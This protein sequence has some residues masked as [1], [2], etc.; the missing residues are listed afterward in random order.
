[1]KKLSLAVLAL[2]LA[3]LAPDRV[4]AQVCATCAASWSTGQAPDMCTTVVVT[5]T[6]HDHG[7]CTL[8]P[9][10]KCL[11]RAVCLFSATVT[12][13]D[14][15]C[16]GAVY[17]SRYCTGAVNSQGQPIGSPICGGIGPFTSPVTL[18]DFPV[19]CGR[20]DWLV[21]ERWLNGV[22]SVIAQPTGSC[23]ACASQAQEGDG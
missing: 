11:P 23:S 12:I 9:E 8:N 7:D 21:F 1:M 14:L 4:A 16:G 15:G 19:A 18:S 17:W 20:S 5:F 22:T 2:V 3:C 10:P 6:R 13:T